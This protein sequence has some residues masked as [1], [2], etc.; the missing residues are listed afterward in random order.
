MF[1]HTH[2]MVSALEPAQAVKRMKVPVLF[3]HGSEDELVPVKTARSLYD[4]CTSPKKEIHIFEGSP[5]AV[6]IET[7]R[8]EYM[9]VREPI[10]RGGCR[11]GLKKSE[12]MHFRYL[13]I[14]LYPTIISIVQNRHLLDMVDAVVCLGYIIR[15][16][17]GMNEQ[18]C[19]AVTISW[20]SIFGRINTVM[21]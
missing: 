13:T 8:S 4:N 9:R 18:E 16:G 3:L 14:S 1:Y 2:K 11:F 10:L 17:N 6:G 7:N 19:S 12:P 15:G 20:G 21:R 5:H